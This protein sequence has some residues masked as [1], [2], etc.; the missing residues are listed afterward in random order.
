MTEDAKIIE[1]VDVIGVS[2]SENGRFDEFD[3]LCQQLFPQIRRRIDD[4]VAR[5]CANDNARPTTF[6]LRVGG[7]A[8]VART[9]DDGN[10]DTGSCS[11]QCEGRRSGHGQRAEEERDCWRPIVSI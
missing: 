5:R 9:T 2:V 4:E 10:A 11:G 6:V 3:L 8:N 1:T 7:S